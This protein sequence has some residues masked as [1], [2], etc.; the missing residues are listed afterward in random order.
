MAMNIGTW[1]ITDAQGNILSPASQGQLDLAATG[2]NEVLQNVRVITNTI[3]GTVMGDR[4]FG[5]NNKYVDAP[6]NKAQLMIAAEVCAGLTH[7]EPRVTFR[8]IQFDINKAT[9]AMDVTLSIVINTSE[10]IPIP[11]HGK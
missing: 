8:K 5:L 10:L 11:T 4:K 2:L 7:F 3:V 1:V 6:Q 9:L